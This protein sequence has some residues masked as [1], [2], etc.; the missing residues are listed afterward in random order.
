ME[1]SVITNN[2]KET[3][4]I[5]RLFLKA[6]L[7]GYCLDPKRKK[8]LIISLEGNLGSGKTEF[9]KGIGDALRIKKDIFSPT[10]L[11][12]KRF[13]LKSK[14]SI[15]ENLWHLDCYRLKN[16][17]EIEG[18]GFR[19]ISKNSRNLMFIEWGNKI[20]TIFPKDYWQIN[21]KIVDKNKRLLTFKIPVKIA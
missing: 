9:M 12:M 10:F 5:A 2:P 18:L 14:S 7:K 19:D 13:S 20:K 4:I 16:I 6:V 3:K 21:F 15:F 1:I 17:K 8:A 11:I